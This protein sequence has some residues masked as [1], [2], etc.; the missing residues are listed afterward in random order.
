MNG[1][2]MKRITPAALA[3]AATFSVCA[4]E[5]DFDGSKEDSFVRRFR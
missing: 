2:M 3:L 5:S 1:P 4:V